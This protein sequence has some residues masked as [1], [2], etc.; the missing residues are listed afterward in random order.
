MKKG[1]DISEHQ[2]SVNYKQLKSAGVEF[3]IIRTSRGTIIDKQY[4]T[5]VAG[6]READIPIPAVYHFCYALNKSQAVAEAKYC[7]SLVESMNL[8]KDTIIFFD[9]EYD[10]I[11]KAAAK[12]V[13]LGRTQCIEFTRAFCDTVKSLG[14]KAGFYANL[15]FCNRM[16]DKATLSDYILWL[17]QYNADDPSVKC[18]FRQYTDKGRLAGYSSNLDLDYFYEET[19]SEKKLY[20]ED[21]IALAK[22]WLG[23]NEADGS[24]RTI[25]D[26]YNTQWPLPRGYRMT[27]WDAWCATFISAIAIKLGMTSIIPTECSCFYMIEGF[28]KL[29]EWKESDSYIPKPGDIIL[30][31]WE[32]NGVGDNQGVPD[33]VGIV[34]KCDGKTITVIEGNCN[35]RVDRRSLAVNGR[36]I[37][38]FGVPKYDVK[39]APKP[40]PKKEPEKPKIEIPPEDGAVFR[41]YNLEQGRHLFTTSCGEANVLANSG[42]TYEGIAWYCTIG[43]EKT[44]PIYRLCSDK[45]HYYTKDPIEV[46]VLKNLG[47]SFEGVAFDADPNAKLPIYQLYNA[48]SGKHFFTI[49]KLEK[50]NLIKLGWKYEKVAF[51][52]YASK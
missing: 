34:E 43:D 45:E 21:A 8:G 11:D 18:A 37:R 39:E 32:D 26:I 24:H 28:K 25:I 20:A 51:Y 16:Y 42:W 35:N 3:A 6:C 19:M 31:D 14:Y 2:V 46:K 10:T 27:Y 13:T 38:G 49:S 15:D 41:L 47:W 17:A 1:I 7:V 23:K 50:D 48:N 4:K 40:E 12:D 33:H 36:Y 22:S 30:Y 29:G 52:G 44:I 5:H 9:F